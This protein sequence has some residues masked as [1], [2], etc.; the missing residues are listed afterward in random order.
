M[1]DSIKTGANSKHHLSEC[2]PVSENQIKRLL[3]EV[4]KLSSDE[5]KAFTLL[6]K[7]AVDKEFS[8][9]AVLVLYY[10]NKPIYH[11]ADVFQALNIYNTSMRKIIEAKEKT[12]AKEL[13]FFCVHSDNSVSILGEVQA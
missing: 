2:K 13:I 1:S 12:K 10:D 4:K 5:L 7:L 8:K 11:G 9:G 3:E 6:L